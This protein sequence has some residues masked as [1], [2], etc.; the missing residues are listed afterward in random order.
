MKKH[1]FEVVFFAV[2]LFLNGCGSS[3]APAEGDLPDS[4][5]GGEWAQW[6]GPNRDGHS[7]TT[8]LPQRW[9]AGEPRQLWRRQ[10]GEGF[11]GISIADGRLFTQFSQDT[12]EFLVAVDA[13]DGSEVWRLAM[14]KTL[15]EGNGNGPR[16]TPAIDG[17][18]VYALG[19]LGKLVAV[20]ADD[21]REI[22]QRDL[23]KA[24]RWG[25]CSSPLVEGDLLIVNGRPGGTAAVL[26]VDKASGETAWVAGEG[27]PGFASPVAVTP[28]LSPSGGTLG[29]KRQ[30][31]SFIGDGL[32]G[33][34]ADSGE[35][36]WRVPWTTSYQVNAADPVFLPPDRIFLSSGYGEGALLVRVRQSGE[37]FR[38]EELWRNPK[39]RNHFNSSVV[40]GE[41]LYGF[42]NATLKCMAIA[43]GEIL[44]GKRGL[45]KGSL[46][47]ADGKLIVLGGKGVLALVEATPEEYRELANVQALEGKCWTSPTLAGRLLYLR[48]HQEIVCLTLESNG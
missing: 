33:L 6:R 27:H 45:G 48:N 9:L 40:V 25:Y 20:A 11:S 21:G 42:D 12:D 2:V 32:V 30:I 22:W 4:G 8:G 5:P 1:G 28:H 29:G 13:R 17:E 46:I 23:V 24:P 7:P 15:I 18:V 44:W 35:E 16:A 37:G 14:G 10:L 36:L 47:T 31:L 41:H 38:V 39:M 34:A 3:P 26:A 19:S 43:T